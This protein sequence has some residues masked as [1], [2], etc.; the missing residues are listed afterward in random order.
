MIERC[1]KECD[2]DAVEVLIFDTLESSANIG[3]SIEVKGDGAAS[4]WDLR[5]MILGFL[6]VGKS[7][8]SR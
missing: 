1:D 5:I 2:G 4:L 7:V 6:K 8:W 3:D